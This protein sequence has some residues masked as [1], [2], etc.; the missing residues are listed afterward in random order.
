MEV[1]LNWKNRFAVEKSKNSGMSSSTLDA[2]KLSLCTVL[3]IRVL[4]DR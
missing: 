1:V 4:T 3:L 2:R